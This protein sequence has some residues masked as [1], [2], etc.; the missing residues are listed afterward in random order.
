MTMKKNI[1]IAII[2]LIAAHVS[3]AN[4]IY[5]FRREIL[6]KSWETT[7]R[8]CDATLVA[9]NRLPPDLPAYHR[10]HYHNMN[11]TMVFFLFFFHGE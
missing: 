3:P 2:M 9:H 8:P 1:I 7:G 4:Q 11:V 5:K 6:G 10:G